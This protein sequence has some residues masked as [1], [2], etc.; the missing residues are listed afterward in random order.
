[1]GKKRR[2]G[3][4]TKS[5][6][7]RKKVE[8]PSFLFFSPRRRRQTMHLASSFPPDPY[9]LFIPRLIFLQSTRVDGFTGPAT[10]QPGSQLLE[11]Q[12]PR[13]RL[14]DLFYP[15]QCRPSLVGKPPFFTQLSRGKDTSFSIVGRLT[16]VFSVDYI[17]SILHS[18]PS[19]SSLPLLL[20]PPLPQFSDTRTT[21]ALFFNVKATSR[22][23]NVHFFS[24]ARDTWLFNSLSPYS[25]YTLLLISDWRSFLLF[26]SF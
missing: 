1:M 25:P 14:A 10:L 23:N 17:L 11:L 22:N 2:N 9:L 16:F 20:S 12:N 7:I 6:R 18:R 3:V 26:I 8:I 15:S 21:R 19:S 24:T 13:P 5:S 4:M